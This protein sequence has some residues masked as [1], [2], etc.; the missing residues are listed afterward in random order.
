MGRGKPAVQFRP[1]EL[2]E[3]GSCSQA[4]LRAITCSCRI[5]RVLLRIFTGANR[6]CS[7]RRHWI[8]RYQADYCSTKR[9]GVAN[10]GR[11]RPLAV[12]QS[13]KLFEFQIS[14]TLYK[15]KRRSTSPM[16][17]CLTVSSS[18]LTSGLQSK[19]STLLTLHSTII[20]LRGPNGR[21]SAIVTRRRKKCTIL[22]K[23]SRDETT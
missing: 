2:Q 16:L 23:Y 14:I 18:T 11:L 6:D 8:G 3:C 21:Q 15:Y 17:T 9:S 12:R 7:H 22:K 19:L 10:N 20:A 4:S 13:T 1:Y 5:E